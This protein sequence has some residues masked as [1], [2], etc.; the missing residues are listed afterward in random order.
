M[1]AP[2]NKESART[3]W[4][5]H[6]N[7][8]AVIVILAL[9]GV[10]WYFKHEYD[11]AQRLELLERQRAKEEREAKDRELALKEAE[12]E[13]ERKEAEDAKRKKAE[14]LAKERLAKQKADEEQRKAEKERQA[15][16]LKAE[17]D[18]RLAERKAAEERQSHEAKAR[19]VDEASKNKNAM[20]EVAA[21]ICFQ[22]D[23]ALKEVSDLSGKLA[24]LEGQVTAYKNRMDA[25]AKTSAGAAKQLGDLEQARHTRVATGHGTSVGVDNTDQIAK[26]KGQADSAAKE[27]R[28]SLSGHEKAL[29]DRDSALSKMK[30]A[31][32]TVDELGP[33]I[34]ALKVDA[35]ARAALVNRAQATGLVLNQTPSNNDVALAMQSIVQAKGDSGAIFG[36]KVAIT[37]VLGAPAPPETKKGE[38]T[39]KKVFILKDGTKIIAVKVVDAG[40]EYS[41]KKEDG[42]FQTIPKESIEKITDE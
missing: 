17:Q 27:Y 13:K 24:G 29:S 36:L 38:S 2:E 14:E 9:L 5:I 41:V 20:V 6:I 16:A 4:W 23:S 1:A 34:T 22:Y 15:A 42:K 19:L 26:A 11:H 37:E 18:R 40:D 31:Q 8:T 7:V 25:A 3:T 10:G 33:T 39:G 21:R 30:A 28:D 35:K 12:R 32:A